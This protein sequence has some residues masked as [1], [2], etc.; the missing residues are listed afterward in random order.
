M[1]TMYSKDGNFYIARFEV[2]VFGK[3][4]NIRAVAPYMPRYA[5][6]EHIFFLFFS[7][8]VQTGWTEWMLWTDK[9]NSPYSLDRLDAIDLNAF[10][11]CFCYRTK[12]L[13]FKLLELPL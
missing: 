6:S 2:Q 13:R 3:E 8:R 11:G 7:E 5:I 1:D 9:A 10:L 4:L 12:E